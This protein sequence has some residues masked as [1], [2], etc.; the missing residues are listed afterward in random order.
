MQNFG[1]IDMNGLISALNR[2]QG[3]GDFND[4]SL[5]NFQKALTASSGYFGYNLEREVKFRLPAYTVLRQRVAVDPG[6][7]G[8][9]AGKQA[10]WK[11]QLGYNGFDF[12]AAMGTA[13]GANGAEGNPDATDIGADYKSQSIHGSTQLEAIDFGRQ[14]TDPIKAQSMFNLQTLMRIEELLVTGG[15]EFAIDHPV[16]VGSGG[17]SG[18]VFHS[19]TFRVKVTA[20]TL[21]GTLR[22]ATAAAANAATLPAVQYP[23]ESVVGTVDIV[24][25]THLYLDVSWPVVQGALGYKV[26]ISDAYNDTADVFLLDPATEMTFKDGGVIVPQFAG[27]KYVGVNHVFITALPAGTTPP[28]TVDGSANANTY[29]GYWAWCTK[30]T[31]YG[32]SLAAAG[33]RV[34]TDMD[35]AEF[36]AENSGVKEVNDAL[37]K[38]ALL[39]HTAPTAMVGSVKTVRAL[40]N[41][42]TGNNNSSMM[43]VGNQ[44][45]NLQQQNKF[46][47]GI[48][49]GGYTNQFAQHYGM[50]PMIDII[51]HP[52][53]PDGSLMLLSETL[54]PDTY[55]FAQDSRCYA[56]D[57]LRPYNYFPL[58]S[59]DRNINFDIWFLETLK[60]YYPT[61]QAAIAGIDV[62]D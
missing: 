2:M 11:M 12:G 31:M 49:I 10:H 52:Y 59:T 47:G 42:S 8:P 41:V 7:Q 46:I 1:M 55:R 17:G 57:V 3:I 56:L 22:N 21:E 15:N 6:P 19:G 18:S 51:A 25:T 14:F 43:L 36:T 50:S 26:Y 29:E 62:S 9:M 37:E 30:T 28:P 5:A 40:T 24:T 54:P 27:G 61:A 20:L 45:G 38:L 34:F 39:Y 58:A 48:M 35:G 23:G 16:P 32:Q 53:M 60:C 4:K 44:G 13:F 33:Q